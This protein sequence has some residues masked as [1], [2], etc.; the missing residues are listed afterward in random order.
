M[1]LLGV[2]EMSDLSP[3]SGPKRTLDQAAATNPDFM[4]TRLA[5]DRHRP[6][7]VSRAVIAI[8]NVS[9]RR[10]LDDVRE[11]N[12]F[13]QLRPPHLIITRADKAVEIEGIIFGSLQLAQPVDR[14]HGGGAGSY[15]DLCGR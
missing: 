14:I 15:R 5:G 2:R 8:I 4:S 12:G 7:S 6:A 13:A 10:C 3:Q 1:S 9:G 11:P